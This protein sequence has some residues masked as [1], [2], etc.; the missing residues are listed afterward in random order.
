MQFYGGWLRGGG[1]TNTVVSGWIRL[2]GGGSSVRGARGPTC[3]TSSKTKS[4]GT[5]SPPRGRRRG[6][7]TRVPAG[8]LR[9]PVPGRGNGAVNCTLWPLGSAFDLI[10]AMHWLL[11]TQPGSSHGNYVTELSGRITSSRTMPYVPEG[12]GLPADR[13]AGDD[14]A[15]C[16]VVRGPRPLGVGMG[17]RR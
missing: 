10:P 11:N 7:S 2:W 14:S 3:R 1:P 16:A 6:T 4:P 5:P 17:L 8:T 9:T 13:G 15:G 12:V